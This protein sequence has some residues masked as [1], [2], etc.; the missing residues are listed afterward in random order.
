MH[1][2]QPRFHVV[3]VDPRKDSARY[4]QENF[5][6]F[7]F[8][9]TQFTAVTAYQNHRVGCP[10][11]PEDQLSSEGQRLRLEGASVP[12]TSAFLLALETLGQG[13]LGPAEQKF[14]GLSVGFQGS[15][16]GAQSTTKLSFC[17]S[18]S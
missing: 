8:T 5:K 7:V 14:P 2:Y 6:S 17:R 12:W 10:T 15:M 3:F 11:D 16:A 1:R 9:E 18:R 4:A 13:G